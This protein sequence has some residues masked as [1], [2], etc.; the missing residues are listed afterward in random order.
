MTLQESIKKLGM[1]QYVVAEAVGVKPD[2]LSHLLKNEQV[3]YKLKDYIKNMEE[4]L[5]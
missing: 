4:K 1:K 3:F 2:I 5:K